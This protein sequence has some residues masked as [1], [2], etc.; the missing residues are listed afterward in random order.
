MKEKI[1]FYDVIN[2]LDAGD[3]IRLKGDMIQLK[4]DKN[5]KEYI[6]FS[7]TDGDIFQSKYGSEIL[8]SK[9]FELVRNYNRKK[10]IKEAFC[11]ERR[12]ER[13]SGY[14]PIDAEFNCDLSFFSNDLNEYKGCSILYE[15]MTEFSKW[16]ITMEEIPFTKEEI[17][18]IKELREK[19]KSN[20]DT[21]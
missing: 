4:K 9:D 8:F 11:I 17:E 12:N 19:A 2:H 5:D 20:N 10:E 14:D 15:E 16:K 18:K 1:S 21:I 7:E 6:C 13:A 3:L